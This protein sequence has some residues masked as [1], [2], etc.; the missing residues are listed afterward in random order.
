MDDYPFRAAQVLLS[1]Q[2][3]EEVR[4]LRDEIE[5][6]AMEVL[7]FK[8][9]P[10]REAVSAFLPRRKLADLPADSKDRADDR[11]ADTSVDSVMEPSPD[12]ADNEADANAGPHPPTY[13]P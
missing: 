12:M 4:V 5:G 9:Y 8:G 10:P 11:T 2:T 3:P 6:T 13:T 7:A 1:S